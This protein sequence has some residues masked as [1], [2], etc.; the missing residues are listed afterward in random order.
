MN[1]W[2]LEQ[3][4]SKAHR[5]RIAW[6]KQRLVE[7]TGRAAREGRV[8]RILNLGCGPAREVQEF[9]SEGRFC[10]HADFTLLDFDQE[11]VEHTAR[12]LEQHRAK[13][14]HATKISV[15]KKS[16]HHFLKEAAKPGASRRYDFIYCAGLLDYLPDRTCRQLTSIFYEWLAPGGAA[17]VTNVV[18]FKPFRHMLEILLDW[19]LVYRDSKEG[20]AL[21][22][23]QVAPTVQTLKRDDTGVNMFIE[24]RK[25]GHG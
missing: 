25:D 9:L 10:N 22:P 16:V 8:C 7:E 21:L 4:P 24:F 18:D 15:L 5:N 19:H 12:V 14:R 3:W 11:T 2:L 20:L 13:H 6:L 23:A 1:L 17:L